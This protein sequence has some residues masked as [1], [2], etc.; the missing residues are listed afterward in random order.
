DVI[1]AISRVFA[2]EEIE[3]FISRHS[4][5]VVWTDQATKKEYKG[6]GVQLDS[7]DS[8]FY[9]LWIYNDAVSYKP[10]SKDDYSYHSISVHYGLNQSTGKLTW[11]PKLEY[12]NSSYNLYSSDLWP[13]TDGNQKVVP[14]PLKKLKVMQ[15]QKLMPSVQIMK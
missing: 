4:E 15:M 8:D 11:T 13:L 9:S 2:D 10:E 3:Q 14:S 12:T 6:Q 1:E 7:R 5:N